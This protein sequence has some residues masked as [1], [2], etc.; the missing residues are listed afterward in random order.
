MKKINRLDF[1]LNLLSRKKQSMITIY[2]NSSIPD[3]DTSGLYCRIKFPIHM[4]ENIQTNLPESELRPEYGFYV[5]GR[6][7][8][9]EKNKIL[10]NLIMNAEPIWKLS[11]DL[12]CNVILDGFILTNLV[13][14][15]DDTSYN[16]ET[17]VCCLNIDSDI[18]EKY[19]V[20]LGYLRNVIRWAEWLIDG[21]SKRVILKH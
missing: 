2:E 20:Q 19:K 9:G 8:P 16:S 21:E 15:Y 3:A 1:F 12:K 17:G 4:S 13:Y 14:L 11:Q 18:A 5:C 6:T 10:I 7:G